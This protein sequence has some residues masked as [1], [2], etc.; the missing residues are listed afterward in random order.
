MTT[1]ANA[2]FIFLFIFRYLRLVVHIVSFHFL[3]KSTPVPANPT[4]FR[5]DCSIIIPTIDPMNPGFR[6]CLKTVLANEPGQLIIV[7]VGDSYYSLTE[8]IVEPLRTQFR[9]TKITVTQ[10]EEANKRKQVAHGLQLVTG[11]ITVLV[12][13]HV[14]W[15]S[16]NF[17]PTI[18]APF[19]DPK[20]GGLGTNK[21]VLRTSRGFS[22]ESIYNFWG[23]VY[24]ERHNFEIRATNA[25]DGGVFVLSGRTSAHRSKILQDPEFLSGFKHERCLF[26]RIG[27]IG[28]DDDNYITRFEVTKGWKLAIQYCEDATIE[29]DLGAPHKYADQC[30][31]WVRTTWRSNACSLFTDRV[32]WTSQPWCVYAVY[33]TS[34]FNFALFYDPLLLATLWLTTFGHSWQ[35]LSYMGLWIFWSKMVKL[36]AHFKRCK[37]DIVLIPW[38]IAFAY[39]H[40][41]LKLG[42]LI[43]FYEVKWM[44]RDL[45]NIE[46][47]AQRELA[48]Y[49]AQDSA[50]TPSSA[51]NE[52][53]PLLT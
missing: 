35:A 29:T 4:L 34:F 21:R 33:F 9:K 51:Q 53:T 32:V 28:P 11:L 26:G 17:L 45:E 31:R 38:Y 25:I 18:L 27:P 44:G 22:W 39:Y 3:Y 41:L 1:S 23:A 6:K 2:V 30:L 8:L 43:T 47:Q 7:T 46:T 36:V 19:E 14:Y 52:T 5:S 10:M 12:D 15:P 13:D 20:V 24:L 48:E 50:R 40:S 37:H 16:T 42:A 49:Q